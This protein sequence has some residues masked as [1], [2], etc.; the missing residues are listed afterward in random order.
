MILEIKISV[1][2]DQ[3]WFEEY[4]VLWPSKQPFNFFVTNQGDTDVA[5][6]IIC[7][8]STVPIIPIYDC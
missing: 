3:M 4:G 7:T 8:M 2:Q 1:L 6:I 5:I